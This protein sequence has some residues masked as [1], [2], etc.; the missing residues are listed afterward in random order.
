MANRPVLHAVENGICF[1]DTVN[2]L[3]NSFSTGKTRSLDW[4]RGQL[5]NLKRMLIENEHDILKALKTDLGKCETEAYTSECGYLLS[6]IEHTLK[7]LN[8]WT[9]PRRVSTPIVAWPGKSFQQPEPLGTVLIIGA[10]NYPLQLLLAP[11]V[12]ALAAGN[13]AVLKP[14]ELSPATSSLVARL[15]PQY[16]DTTTVTV[17]EGAKDE[18]TALLAC[19]WDH[20][21]YTG[22]EVVGKI[23]M[24]AAARHLTPVTLELGGKSPCIIDKH[25]NLKVTARRLVWGKWMNSGQTC[26]APDYVLVEKGQEN[27]LIDAIKKEL[28]SQYGKDPL[29]SRDFGN[30]VNTRHLQRLKDYLEGAPVVYGGQIDEARPAMSP[31]IVLNPSLDSKV[32]QEEIFGPI[33]PI[34]TVESI[35]EAIGFINQRP[36]P[37]ALYAFSDDDSVLEK[38][39]A[40]TS[41]G[42]VCTNDTMMFMTNPELPFGGVGNSGMGN[43]HGRAGFDTFSHLKTVMK[44][45]FALD[46]PFRYAP[47]SK[48][49]LSLLKKLL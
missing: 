44:R 37:L 26:I 22:G 28:K 4:R 40:Q 47:Y 3:K 38:I 2:A 29:A 13:C 18:A 39:I 33:L 6:D 34:V 19:H 43:Y 36:K 24:A 41:S 30:I 8:K 46:A 42:S 20:I 35:E 10:W 14:S 21:F 7:H 32:M 15:I 23:V 16:M 12:A 11:Y 25:T 1:V 9:K 27:Q 45:A 49:K 48:L 17:V 5:E 31:T